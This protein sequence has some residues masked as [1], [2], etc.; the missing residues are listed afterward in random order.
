[1]IEKESVIMAV[2]AAIE[3]LSRKIEQINEGDIG[4]SE[5]GDWLHNCGDLVVSALEEARDYITK[6][7]VN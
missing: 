2:D 7:A 1:M 5:A 6:E 4:F 3:R